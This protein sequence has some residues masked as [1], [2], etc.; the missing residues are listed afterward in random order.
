MHVGNRYLLNLLPA[1]NNNNAGLYD[2]INN[3]FY[4]NSGTGIISAGPD[5]IVP[6]IYTDKIIANN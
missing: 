1:L 3:K 6:S 5:L 4:S 2:T